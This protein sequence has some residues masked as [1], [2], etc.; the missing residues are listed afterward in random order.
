MKKKHEKAAEKVTMEIDKLRKEPMKLFIS[1]FMT[2]IMLILTAYAWD[3]IP[4]RLCICIAASVFSGGVILMPRFSNRVSIPLLAVYLLYVP[5]KIFDRMELPVHNMEHL[6]DGA[7]ELTA[8]FI[9]CTFLLIFLF[10]QNTAAALG[11]GSGFFLILFLVEYYIWK[12]RGDFLKPGDISAASTALSV[13]KGFEY[14]LSPEALY[15]I[16]YFLFFIILGAKIRINMN[17]AVHIGVSVAAFLFISGWYFTVMEKEKPLGREFEV[18]YWTP[19]A[20]RLFNGACLSY[21]LFWKDSKID[22][23]AGYSE[24]E[25]NIIAEM[26]VKEH[27]DKK[28]ARQKPDIIMIMGEAWSDLSVLGDLEITG[29]CMPYINGLEENIIKGDLYVSILG[30][31]TANTEFEALTGDSL[32]LLS[33][34]VV[35]YQNQVKHDMSS[36][37]E[38]LEEQGYRTMAMHPSTKIAWNREHVYSCFGF[39]EFIDAEKWAVPYE[40][41]RGFISDACNYKEIIYR[42]ENRDQDNSFFLFDVTI[43]NHAGYYKGELPLDIRIKNIE[44]DSLAET[45]SV[46]AVE[47]YLNLM[48]KADNDLN[49]LIVYFEKVERPVIICV[50]GDHQP[51]LEDDFYQAVFADSGLS[52]REQNLQK[53]VTPYI[54]WANYDVDWQ[55]YGNMSANYLPAVLMEC[56]GLELPPFYQYLMELHGEYPVLTQRGCLDTDGNLIDIDTIWDTE[57][58]S[59]YRMLQ[60]NQLYVEDYEKEI[61]R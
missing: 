57:Q 17:K 16:V 30:G 26:A 2:V 24:E 6:V 51:K 28:K 36:L 43:Q 25:L 22:V 54:I 59:R 58:I 52:K 18:I 61:F 10:T 56:A 32:A 39:D 42:Y 35:P 37:V 50:F 33:P 47:T 41:E 38:V 21:F 4:K 15:S 7:A 31:L 13:M 48:K 3:G 60:Y 11:A 14:N 9:I 49:D 5:M 53:Y 45:E 40:H 34:S 20:T 8:A 29:D 19:S 46:D 55:E 1:A 44:T 23:P 12:F 27:D